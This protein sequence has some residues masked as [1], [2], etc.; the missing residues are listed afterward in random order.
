[1]GKD[2]SCWAGKMGEEGQ[3]VQISN[4]KSWGSNVHHGDSIE[5]YNS[6]HLKVT[7]KVNPKSSHPKGK[8]I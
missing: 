2:G 5:K 4:Y 7:R 1:M 6:A 8:K 3:D